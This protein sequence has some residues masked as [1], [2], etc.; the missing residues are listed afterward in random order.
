MQEQYLDAERF[1][2]V[3]PEDLPHFAE[4]RKDQRAVPDVQ[5]LLEHLRKPRQFSAASR[6]RGLILQELRRMVADLL[7]LHQRR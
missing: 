6:N 5:G 1:L 3:A 4:L 2:Q 7:E